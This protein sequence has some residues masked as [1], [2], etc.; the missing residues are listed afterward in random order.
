MNL[1]QFLKDDLG[2]VAKEAKC[3][4]DLQEDLKAKVAACDTEGVHRACKDI[5]KSI[6]SLAALKA[7]K[8]RQKELKQVS[9][10]LHEQGVLCTVVRRYENEKAQTS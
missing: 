6:Q 5:G 10:M 8:D 7:K 2:M 9:Q 4:K 1:N 3:L